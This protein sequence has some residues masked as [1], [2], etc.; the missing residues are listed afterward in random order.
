MCPCGA[1]T[2][3]VICKEW[4]RSRSVRKARTRRS[5]RRLARGQCGPSWRDSLTG[6]ALVK[7]RRWGSKKSRFVEAAF[8]RMPAP[9]CGQ[10][11][12]RAAPGSNHVLLVD[13]LSADVQ[14][15]ALAILLGQQV[16]IQAGTLT[17][18]V[19]AAVVDHLSCTHHDDPVE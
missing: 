15:R 9:A 8:F 19:G 1:I 6:C 11:S 13:L 10:L 18:L 2:S 12:H 5:Q 4:E 7:R 16:A 14:C 17:Q 3:C